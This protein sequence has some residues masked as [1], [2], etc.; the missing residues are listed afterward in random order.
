MTV[1]GEVRIQEAAIESAISLLLDTYA[2]LEA[3]GVSPAQGEL[4]A[5]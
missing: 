2:L 5:R 1:L 3:A 4:D